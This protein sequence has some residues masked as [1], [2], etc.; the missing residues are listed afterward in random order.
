MCVYRSPFEKGDI[1]ITFDITFPPQ[2]FADTDQLSVRYFRYN[3][4]PLY[5][6]V[7]YSSTP[8][9][10]HSHSKGHLSCQISDL[11]R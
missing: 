6:H 5:G 11:L 2:N 9:Y 1:Y 7:R 10:G 8:L 3:C 4:T